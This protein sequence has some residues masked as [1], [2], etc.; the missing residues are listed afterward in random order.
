MPKF[1]WPDHVREERALLA[2]EIIWTLHDH[3]PIESED[4]RATSVLLS[5]LKEQGWNHSSGWLTKILVELG[6]GGDLG[7]FV[8]REIQG[9]RTYRIAGTR[10]PSRHPFPPDPRRKL[11]PVEEDDPERED[12]PDDET[13]WSDLDAVYIEDEVSAPELVPGMEID[14]IDPPSR[15]DRY[16]YMV[17]LLNEMITEEVTAPERQFEQQIEARLTAVN[18]IL[19]ENAKLKNENERLRGD[20]RKLAAAL[21]QANAMMRDRASRESNSSRDLARVTA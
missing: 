17:S 6:D 7:H 21:E 1:A 3:G 8:D 11:D 12:Q 9:K 4:G 2:A 5:L 15:V 14:L 19:E 10:T 16:L 20:K 13:E 18:S